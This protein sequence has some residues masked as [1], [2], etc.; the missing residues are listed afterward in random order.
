M[1]LN[2]LFERSSGSGLIELVGSLAE[3]VN[4]ANRKTFHCP[5]SMMAGGGVALLAV[6]LRKKQEF[7]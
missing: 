4:M 2:I 7:R 3:R 6:M 1:V 5:W